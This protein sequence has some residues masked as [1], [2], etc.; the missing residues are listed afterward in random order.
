MLRNLTVAEN[1]NM[2]KLPAVANL[3][4]NKHFEFIVS[5]CDQGYGPG[6]NFMIFRFDPLEAEP[7]LPTAEKRKHH[8]GSSHNPK[9]TS[10]TEINCTPQMQGEPSGDETTPIATPAE[11]LSGTLQKPP[12]S[13]T[14]RI[15]SCAR[16]LNF[17]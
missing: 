8:A 11:K 1:M 2:Q 15:K 3:I 14:K 6:L 7:N 10:Q 12:E 17:K 5:L 4:M 16:K 9:E 13:A